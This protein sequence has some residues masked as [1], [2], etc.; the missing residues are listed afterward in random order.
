MAG[1]WVRLVIVFLGLGQRGF[2]GVLRFLLDGFAVLIFEFGNSKEKALPLRD[3]EVFSG[4][5]EGPFSPKA[6]GS[7]G[8][9]LYI[10]NTLEQSLPFLSSFFLT[11]LPKKNRIVPRMGMFYTKGN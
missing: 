2:A 6:F 4:P 7:A 3:Y 11:S 10:Y 9:Y 8:G 1:F 5:V